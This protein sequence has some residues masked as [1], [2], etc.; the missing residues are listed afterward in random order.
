MDCSCVFENYGKML[1]NITAIKSRVGDADEDNVI[2][3]KHLLIV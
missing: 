3:I 2:L 1:N